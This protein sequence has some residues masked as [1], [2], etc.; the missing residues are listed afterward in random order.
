MTSTTAREHGVSFKRLRACLP[1]F[2]DATRYPASVKFN[3]TN[4]TMLGS[5]STTSILSIMVPPPAVVIRSISRS[6][7]RRVGKECRSRWAPDQYKEKKREWACTEGVSE[8]CG[9]SLS[10][11]G[12]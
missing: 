1:S 11:S 4:F 6:E 7:E 2:A 10:E 8:E 9:R 12:G 5:S 3:V